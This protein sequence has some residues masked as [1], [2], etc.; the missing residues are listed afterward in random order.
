MTE[1]F[2]CNFIF[3]CTLCLCEFV[4]ICTS[5]FVSYQWVISHYDWFNMVQQHCCSS[6]K[7]KSLLVNPHRCTIACGG[8]SRGNWNHQ[9]AKDLSWVILKSFLDCLPRSPLL[10]VQTDYLQQH[11][12]GTTSKHFCCKTQLLFSS[13]PFCWY[14]Q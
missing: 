11:I 10:L 2:T 3:I 14:W 8:S 13:H 4:C 12:F 6:A 7:S 5:Y 1:Y 9:P